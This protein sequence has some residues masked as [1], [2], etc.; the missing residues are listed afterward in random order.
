MQSSRQFSFSNL[1][2]Q[3]KILIGVCAPLILLVMLAGIVVYNLGS[4]MTANKSVDYTHEIL[5]DAAAIVSSAVD[6]ETGMRGYLL[7][8]KEGFL[9]PYNNGEKTTYAGIAALQA[10]VSDNPPQVARLVDAEKI[11][12]AWQAD[13][14]EPTIEL[15]RQIGDAK[16]MNDMAAL[17]GEARGKVFF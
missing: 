7:A 15:R 2:T 16:T 10:V 11:M 4:I 17:V 3:P 14:T 5:A 6:M 13:V 1:K 9:A 12:R 8:G